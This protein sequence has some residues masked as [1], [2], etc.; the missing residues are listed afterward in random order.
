MRRRLLFHRL[1]GEWKRDDWKPFLWLAISASPVIINIFTL[2]NDAF[3]REFIVGCSLFLIGL[4]L[5]G[6]LLR[7]YFERTPAVAL[8]RRGL[9]IRRGVFKAATSSDAITIPWS[10][11][12]GV[13]PVEPTTLR[14]LG[15]RLRDPDAILRCYP[16]G[17]QRILRDRLAKGKPPIWIPLLNDLSIDELAQLVDEYKAANGV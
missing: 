14:Y 16:A 8:D 12:A 3:L 4:A 1:P 2:K 15:I 9:M 11:I 13:E 6:F 17:E 7:K 5:S 10:N